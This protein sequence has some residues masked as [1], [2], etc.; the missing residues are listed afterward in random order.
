[1]AGRDLPIAG[2]EPPVPRNVN[3]TFDAN[4]LEPKVNEFGHTSAKQAA[5]IAK[6]AKVG[7]F[8]LFHY[9]PRVE[10]LDLYVAQY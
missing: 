2:H 9:S 8:Y 1:M 7:R 4:S 6:A 5:E 3:L 10:N